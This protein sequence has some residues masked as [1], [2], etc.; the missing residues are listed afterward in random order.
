[1]KKS[2]KSL[3]F[4]VLAGAMSFAL[5]GC[6]GNGDKEDSDHPQGDHPQSEHPESD[7]PN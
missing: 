2:F 4:L 1:M 6:N 7:H 5:A 3:A